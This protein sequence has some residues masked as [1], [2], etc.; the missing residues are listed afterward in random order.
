[1]DNQEQPVELEEK[2]APVLE[3]LPVEESEVLVEE[4]QEKV[5]EAPVVEEPVE[6]VEEESEFNCPQCS[7]TGL[8]DQ[9]NVCIKC[10]GTGKV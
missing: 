4:P 9:F 5:E 6:E 1:M 3:T 7:G 10:G 2:K 8:K